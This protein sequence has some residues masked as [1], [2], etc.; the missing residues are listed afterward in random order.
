MERTG[1]DTHLA[2]E[3]MMVSAYGSQLV[4]GQMCCE[5]IQVAG[6]ADARHF[7]AG[8][9]LKGGKR[10]ALRGRVIAWFGWRDD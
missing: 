3:L 5:D 7:P 4:V 9:C 8:K 1:R 2:E 10:I 6:T